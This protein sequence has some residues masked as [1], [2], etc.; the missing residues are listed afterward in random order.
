MKQDLKICISTQKNTH[1]W[2]GFFLKVIYSYKRRKQ[3]QKSKKKD[4]NKV[5]L[6]LLISSNHRLSEAINSLAELLVGLI[7]T[8]SS[9][10]YVYFI[11]R[12]PIL[13]MKFIQSIVSVN[14][15][16]VSLAYWIGWASAKSNQIK[17]NQLTKDLILR[18]K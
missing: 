11:Q 8:D 6:F 1:P 2:V 18:N 16:S 14:S 17:S 9:L 13:D 4:K 10:R 15:F 3:K 12:Q 5:Y 7:L